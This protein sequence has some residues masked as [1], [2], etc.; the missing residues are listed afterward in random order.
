[1]LIGT[2]NQLIDPQI[3]CEMEGYESRRSTGRHDHLT[4][5]VFYL[6]NGETR[7]LFIALD[8]VAVPGYRADRIKRQ[9]TA[10]W[11]VPAEQVVIAAIHTHSG[12]TVT[13]LL[14]DYPD[15]DETY[16]R[17]IDTQ[18]LKAVANAIQNAQPGR[19]ALRTATV[20]DGIYANRDRATMPYNRQLAQLV[21][22]DEEDKLFGAL[23]LLGTHPTI[24]NVKNTQLSADLVGGVRQAYQKRFGI[25]P[26]VMLTDCGNTSTRYTRRE[27]TFAEVTQKSEQLVAG[28]ITATDKPVTL[29]RLK[30]QQVTLTSD[31]NPVTN[32]DAQVLWTK[33]NNETQAA[34]GA[35]QDELKGF[36][37]TYQ[38]IRDFGHTHF[39]THSTILD[40]GE[41]R[42]VTYPGELVHTLGARIRHADAKPTLLVTL[43]NDYRGYSVNQEDFGQY[44]ESYNSV[45]LRGAADEF[46]ARIVA[47]Q[48]IM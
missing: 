43:A 28:L 47:T 19:L 15:I 2:D 10:K 27:S 42:L 21:A 17:Q 12:P 14:L 9:V 46:V 34:T 4:T 23:L 11:Q 33:I 48:K 38:H 1:M 44:F 24:M 40:C 13:D 36:L 30:C 7:L 29:D 26:V 25:R 8:I 31:Y 22:L 37:S 20:P 32:P 45:L 41:F 18:T 6:A 5:S 35:R 3:G 16:W 39:E